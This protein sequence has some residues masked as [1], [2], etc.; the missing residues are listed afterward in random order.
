MTDKEIVIEINEYMNKTAK[1][2]INNL[3]ELIQDKEPTMSYVVKGEEFQLYIKPINSYI[4]DSSINIYLNECEEILKQKNPSSF[5]TIVQINLKNNHSNC[6]VDQVEYKIYDDN[7]QSVD[8]SICNEVDIK[9]EYKIQNTSLINMDQVKTFNDKGIDVFNI[10]DTF[11]NDICYPYTDGDSN[12]DMILSDRVSDIFQNYSICGD[13]CEYD[14]FDINKT[15]ANCKCKIQTKVK[16]EVKEGNFESSI[17][18]AFFDSNFGVIKCYNIV[19]GLKGKLK[20]S[21]FWI[22]CI[23]TAFHI[24]AYIFLLI[25]GINPIQSY[26]K[27]EMSNKGYMVNNNENITIPK[28]ESIPRI[29][30]NKNMLTTFK[31]TVDNEGE[32]ASPPPKKKKSVFKRK[33]KANLKIISENSN[34][35]SK[36]NNENEKNK[37]QIENFDENIL[38]NPQKRQSMKNFKYNNNLITR[39]D[40]DTL[41]N[42]PNVKRVKRI[43]KTN[44][45]V[46]SNYTFKIS[47]REVIKEKEKEIKSI[48]LENQN[49]DKKEDINDRE[50]PLILI[51]ANNSE[52]KEILK[53]NH[54]LN[55]YNY[56]EAVLYEERTF[57]RIFF[58]YLISKENLLNL[59]FFNPPLE[60]KPLRICVFIF[61]YACD[62]A[63]NALFYLSQNI[64]DKYHYKGP[65]R[66]FYSLIN[67]ITKTIVSTVVGYILLFIFQ[68]LSQSS[69][70]IIKI[71][72]A[73]EDLLK[74][75]KTYKVDDETKIK[76]SND[77][78]KILKCLK[79]KIIFFFIFEL[80]FIL[81]FFY[82]V[83]AFCHVYQN[84]QVSWLLDSL[85][86]HIISFAITLA[87]SLT[88]ALL[89]KISIK[90]KIKILYK[91]S[92]L[93][94]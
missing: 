57:L 10:K 87:L 14:S 59:I 4:E 15:S 9:V 30:S 74:K 84:T 1:E 23:F 11:F 42:E 31:E 68:S 65:N 78:K 22:F 61:N 41:I 3:D 36:I 21:G 34:N 17:E 64:S 67:N 79:I 29:E 90:Q 83:T 24:P 49:E 5:Y 27:N 26:I 66:I 7:K 8:L 62:L 44:K 12:S 50:F 13:N 60:L 88:L 77:I 73:Q 47:E 58:I 6:L 45:E 19:F 76:I 43:K 72:R 75:D 55:I 70:N 94:Y 20:N 93:I 71:F 46:A 16:E 89:Y 33:T 80:L 38:R 81:F 85:V 53:S 39:T 37:N 69:T 52:K 18:S 91:I 92:L 82:Y 28:D 35:D 32:N 54:K 25:N 48:E 56:D 51:N 2:M 40:L 63:L 86:S